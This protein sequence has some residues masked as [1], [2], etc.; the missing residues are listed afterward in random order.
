[1]LSIGRVCPP[2]PARPARAG[3]RRFGPLSAPR[4]HAKAPHRIELPR[5]ALSAV[6]L[7]RR[8]GRARTGSSIGASSR[9]QRLM[10][11]NVDGNPT[12]AGPAARK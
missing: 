1:M 7:V 4:A 12:C 5:R 11:R 10:Q 6:E 9:R 2:R 8:P 3:T